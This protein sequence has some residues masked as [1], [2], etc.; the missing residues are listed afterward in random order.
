MRLAVVALALPTIAT[1]V[2][3]LLWP[4]GWFDGF[5]GWDPRVVAALPPFNEHLATD[6]GAGLFA[7]GIVLVAA[8]WM[9]TRPAIKVGLVGYAAFTIPHAAWHVVNPADAL[10]TSED[11]V[12]AATLVFSAVACLVLLIAVDRSKADAATIPTRND[13]ESSPR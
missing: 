1:G 3:A 10:T 6:A 5:P 2:W 7:S 9:A 12:N 8:A 4:Q 13:M 11:V